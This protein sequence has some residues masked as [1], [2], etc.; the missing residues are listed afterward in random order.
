MKFR[1]C[2]PERRRAVA[3]SVKDFQRPAPFIPKSKGH[4]AEWIH[5]CKTGEPTTCNFLY[6][7]PLTIANHL[8]NVAFRAVAKLESD[9]VKLAAKNCPAAAP[10]IRR[11]YRQGWKLA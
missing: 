5:A 4:H 7:G 3:S 10:F 11:S 8:G 6:S 1:N 2:S 9:P